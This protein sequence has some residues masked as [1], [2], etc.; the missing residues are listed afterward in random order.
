MADRAIAERRIMAQMHVGF[1]ETCETW[2]TYAQA[3][4]KDD[5]N[6]IPRRAGAYPLRSIIS[7]PICSEKYLKMSKF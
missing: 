4:A 1:H 3:K 5:D 7:E 6:V 2:D